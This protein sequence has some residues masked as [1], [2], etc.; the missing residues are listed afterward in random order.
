MNMKRISRLPALGAI[1]A[2]NCFLLGPAKA[3]TGITPP[4]PARAAAPS[5]FFA[6]SQRTAADL[7]G[8]VRKDSAEPG[9]LRLGAALASAADCAINTDATLAL[10][11]AELLARILSFD[12]ACM[13]RQ[14]AFFAVS[15]A[16]MRYYSNS[17]MQ[18]VAAA[19]ALRAADYTP[20][21]PH[22][23][24]QMMAYLRAGHFVA[25]Y[26]GG[27]LAYTPATRSAVESGL[28]AFAANPY[29]IDP[30]PAH[31]LVLSDYFGAADGA[32]RSGTLAHTGFRYLNA[33]IGNPAYRNR[34]QLGAASEFLGMLIRN[35]GNGDAALAQLIESNGSLYQDILYRAAASLREPFGEAP[36]AG[37]RAAYNS[38]LA[39][40]YMLK[41]AAARPLVLERM[42]ALLTGYERFGGPFVAIASVVDY[43]GVECASLGLCRAALEPELRALAFPNTFRFDDGKLVMETALDL[44]KARQLYLAIKQVKAQY[45]R[46]TQAGSPLPEDP[47]EVLT[48][49][50]YG[51]LSAY[52]NWQYYLHGLNTD[53]GGIYI[54]RGA[55]FYTYERTPAES[56]LTLEEL[57]RHECSATRFMTTTG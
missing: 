13:N 46:K 38:A 10:N 55:T 40:A 3:D 32:E 29:F 50:V 20:E 56:T 51:T 48:M 52:E 23:V 2:L 22:G 53:N 44:S 43:L 21:A 24:Q 27:A 14:S 33:H 54:E 7:T 31:G 11:S 45:L 4:Q 12:A 41:Y 49:R 17:N 57:L 8:A 6:T 18:F 42:P 19:L 15:D 34:N 47:N 1:L 39:Y 9:R 5:P 36:A 26:S 16:T 30:S 25:W 28:L 35:T 37:E